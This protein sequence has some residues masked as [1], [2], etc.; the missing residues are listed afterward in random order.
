VAFFDCPRLQARFQGLF[1]RFPIP[2]N[3]AI[4]RWNSRELFGV[5]PGYRETFDLDQMI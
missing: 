3:W 5:L 1:F 2:M 4:P